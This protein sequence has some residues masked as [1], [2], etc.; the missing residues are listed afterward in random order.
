LAAECLCSPAAWRSRHANSRAF[1][2]QFGESDG[3]A[4]G[5]VHGCAD[6]CASEPIAHG[7]TS[8]CR[9]VHGEGSFKATQHQGF[10]RVALRAL[11]KRAQ[12]A[13]IQEQFHALWAA[14]RIACLQ[15]GHDIC[16]RCV[17]RLVRL[18]PKID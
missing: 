15:Q 18:S 13:S 8:H 4:P 2:S 14:H 6:F 9:C 11:R 1:A 12:L 3:Q 16:G 5:F 7:F 17:W 10:C